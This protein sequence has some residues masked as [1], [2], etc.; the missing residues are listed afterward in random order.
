MKRMLIAAA[1][2]ALLAFGAAAPAQARMANPTLNAVAPATPLL[3]DVH[4]RSYRHSH[5]RY[6]GYQ[7]PY[8]GYR[9][10]YRSSRRCYNE[11]VRV[12]V[13]GVGI[14]FRTQR[15]CGWR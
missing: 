6:R 13:P 4:Y 3:Q 11:R 7:R 2:V 9:S 1:A 8:Y 15:R 5:R 14:V 10:G 12:R